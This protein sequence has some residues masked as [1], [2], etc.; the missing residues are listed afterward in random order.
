MKGC[1][2]LQR[3]FAPIGHVALELKNK[4]EVN[5]FCGYVIA[6]N[7]EYFAKSRKDIVYTDLLMDEDL[8]NRSKNEKLDIEYLK[9]LNPNMASQIWPFIAIDRIS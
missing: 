7:A 9:G 6:R 2:V 3:R 5:E 4:Y 1:I 8:R